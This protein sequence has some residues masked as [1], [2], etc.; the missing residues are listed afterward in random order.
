MIEGLILE[1]RWRV[2]DLVEGSGSRYCVDV[3]DGV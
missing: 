3:G 2:G 1:R